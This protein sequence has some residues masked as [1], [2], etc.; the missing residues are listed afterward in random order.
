MANNR[1]FM[2]CKI[3]GECCFMAKYFIGEFWY[4]NNQEETSKELYNFLY[5]HM[6]NN[7]YY[8]VETFE[9]AY[10]TNKTLQYYNAGGGVNLMAKYKPKKLK[11][12]QLTN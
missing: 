2:G 5:K 7:E 10:E 4:S 6:H 3:C 1:M 9:I 12:I 8:E 11:T